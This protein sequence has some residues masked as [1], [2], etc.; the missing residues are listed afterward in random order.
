MPYDQHDRST[1][2]LVGDV[3]SQATTLLR[4]EG[5]LARAEVSEKISQ[6]T[7]GFTLLL[8]GAVLLIPALV[9]LLDALVLAL[10]AR[11]FSPTAAALLV[12]GIALVFGAVLVLVGKN[13]L[14]PS[15][16]A[17]T[18]TVHQLQR[19]AATAQDQIKA[20]PYVR[21]NHVQGNRAA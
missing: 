16:L 11:E 3:L 21:T 18:R 20:T 1:V 5:R 9:I 17:P 15:N 12:G 6:A 7:G 2:D 8:V 14:A 13:R 19:D 10:V 4:Q